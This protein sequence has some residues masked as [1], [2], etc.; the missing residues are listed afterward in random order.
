MVSSPIKG[1]GSLLPASLEGGGLGGARLLD[2]H[3]GGSCCQVH[4]LEH[5]VGGGVNLTGTG[6]AGSL[7]SYYLA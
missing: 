2:G 7:A 4:G 5:L 3:L 1:G 6:A